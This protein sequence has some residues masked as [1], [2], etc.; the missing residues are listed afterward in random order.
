MQ[1]GND[2]YQSICVASDG[3]ATADPANRTTATTKLPN[4]NGFKVGGEIFYV[5]TGYNAGANI[6]GTGAMYHGYQRLFDARYA[7]NVTRAAGQL[8][9]YE[10]LYL[11]GTIDTSNGLYYLDNP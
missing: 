8:T 10:K 6:S 4:P 9:P 3:T 2:T 7:F 5:A 1:D 11:V